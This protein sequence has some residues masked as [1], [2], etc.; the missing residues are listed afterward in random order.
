MS[1]ITLQVPDDLTERLRPQQ[2]RLA[3]ILELGLREFHAA[4]QGGF[5]GAGEVLEFL[6]TLPAPEEIL[7]LR[8]S[9]RLQHRIEEL[10]EKSRA[11]E[12]TLQDEQEWERFQYLEHLVR[13][14]KTAAQLKLRSPAPSA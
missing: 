8:P 13:M 7:Q 2:D 3:E 5:E 14:A 10:L 12:L 6:A 11:G 9:E 4:A 1:A